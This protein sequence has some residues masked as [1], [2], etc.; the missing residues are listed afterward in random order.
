MELPAAIPSSEISLPGPAREVGLPA[1]PVY[2]GEDDF[3]ALPL[4]GSLTPPP[5]GSHPVSALGLLAQLD[6]SAATV[7]TRRVD[8]LSRPSPFG[9]MHMVGPGNAAAFLGNPSALYIGM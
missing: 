7:A 8:S 4:P 2:L 1:S 6:E 3:F 5:P 9:D